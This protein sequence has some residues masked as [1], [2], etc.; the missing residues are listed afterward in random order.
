MRRGRWWEARGWERE[1]EK[2]VQRSI[3]EQTA[4]TTSFVFCCVGLGTSSKHRLCWWKIRFISLD[5]CCAGSLVCTWSLVSRLWYCGCFHTL[6]AVWNFR[7]PHRREHKCQNQS[8]W[9]VNC[10]AAR[11]HGKTCETC[12]MV[13]RLRLIFCRLY[14]LLGVVPFPASCVVGP[15]S[16]LIL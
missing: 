1:E 10:L 4:D 2:E 12:A 7:T 11:F 6:T 3:K 5:V 15:G 13:T 9:M 8:D 16:C 14:C